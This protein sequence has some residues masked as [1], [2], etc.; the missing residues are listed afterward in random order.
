MVSVGLEM[1]GAA[2]TA[3]ITR[4]AAKDLGLSTGDDVTALIKATDLSLATI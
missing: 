3:A 2:L 1:R 4:S